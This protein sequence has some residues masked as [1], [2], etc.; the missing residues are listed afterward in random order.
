MGTGCLHI[1]LIMNNAEMKIRRHI[2]LKGADFVLFNY[3]LSREI[4][5]SYS[6]SIF[7]FLRNL[8]IIFSNGHANLHSN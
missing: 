2:F 4:A 1:S 3:I 5:G 6:T 8:H 7:S